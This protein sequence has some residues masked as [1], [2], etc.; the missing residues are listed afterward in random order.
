MGLEREDVFCVK[1]LTEAFEKVVQKGTPLELLQEM[2]ELVPRGIKDV[3]CWD[4]AGLGIPCPA[5]V[6]T[7]S[8]C[9]QGRVARV[10]AGKISSG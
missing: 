6:E 2:R 4:F 8:S 3:L 9:F 1:A 5:A 7:C 10:P